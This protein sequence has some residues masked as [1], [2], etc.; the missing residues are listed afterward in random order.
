MDC[1]RRDFLFAGVSVGVVGMAG[2]VAYGGECAPALP[3]DGC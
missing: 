2:N 1:S 3:C